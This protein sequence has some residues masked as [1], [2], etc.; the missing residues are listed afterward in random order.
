MLDTRIHRFLTHYHP[1]PHTLSKPCFSPCGTFIFASVSGMVSVFKTESGRLVT[2]YSSQIIPS[3]PNAQVI[4]ANYHP[5]D[6]TIAFSIY[7]HQGFLV[8]KWDKDHPE[9]KLEPI[10]LTDKFGKH[11]DVEEIVKRSMEGLNVDT[12]ALSVPAI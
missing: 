8:F 12:Q 3:F 10:K 7:G 9:L 4:E 11:L 1:H 6:H 5:F 2:A